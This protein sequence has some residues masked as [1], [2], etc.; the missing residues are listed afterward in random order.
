MNRNKNEKNGPS[1]NARILA[2]VLAAIMIFGVAATLI[3]VLLESG[4][5]H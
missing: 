3:A 1:R 4:H 2:F 5:V